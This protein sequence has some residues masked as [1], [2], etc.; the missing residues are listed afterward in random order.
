MTDR[1]YDLILVGATG[2][3]GRLTAAYLAKSAP[4]DLRIA[5]AGRSQDKLERVRADLPQAAHDWPLLTVDVT[6]AQAAADISAASRVIVTTVGPYA[7]YGRELIAACA[8]HG[9]HYADLTG[10]VLFVHEAITQHHHRA[11]ETGARLVPS[12]GF[13]SVPSD[14]GVMLADQAAAAAGEGRVVEATLHVR[15]AKGGFSGGTIDSMRQQMIAMRSDPSTRRIV[16]NPDALAAERTTYGH[17]PSPIGKDRSTGRWHGPFVM[18]GYNTRVVR[19]SA[20]LTHGN[21]P[22]LYEEV[23]DTGLGVKGAVIAAG[24]A[25]G[26]AGLA[27]SMATA[28]TRKVLDRLLPA[29]GEGPSAEQRE[30]GMFEIEIQA[31]TTTGARYLVTVAAPYDP[32][33]DGTAVMLGES[34][35]ALAAGEGG[36]RAGV[37]TPATA[38][39][40]AL[41]DRLRARDFTLTVTRQ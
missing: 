18:S 1:E 37:L 23:V 17:G 11:V 29:P 22:L 9:T 16:A 10:E 8:E 41:V 4:S 7:T 28:P 15:R 32:G 20:S 38:L 35:L 6:D 36:D 3:V 27:A 34:G 24:V 39:G 19:R 5:L 30:A 21:A 26:T 25:A 14:L 12:C 40:E 31:E 33:Y 13:D 2:F